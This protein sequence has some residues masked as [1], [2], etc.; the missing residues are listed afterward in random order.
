MERM[1]TRAPND[2]AVIARELAF[3]RTPIKGVAAD[4]TH[5]IPCFPRPYAHCMPLLYLHLERHAAPVLTTAYMADTSMLTFK[6]QL[7][8]QQ[9]LLARQP[10]TI[11]VPKHQLHVLEKNFT[12]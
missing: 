7:V 8:Q 1:A 4:A 2:R 6:H 11:A 10:R 5:V 3:W 12:S 9:L